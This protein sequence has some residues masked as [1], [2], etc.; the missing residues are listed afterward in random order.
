MK[1]TTLVLLACAWLQPAGMTPAMPTAIRVQD[2]DDDFR[3]EFQK[4]LDGAQKAEQQKLVKAKSHEA[5]VWIDRI[6][7]KLSVEPDPA[8]QKLFDALSE[9]WRANFAKSEFPARSQSYY[10]SLD[11]SKRRIRKD[12]TDR[13]K[14]AWREFDGNLQKK[15]GLVFANILDEV[16]ALAGAFESEGDLFHASEAYRVH[17]QMQDEVLRGMSADLHGAWKSY[18][19]AIGP[20]EKLDLKD[21]VLE[22][23][24]KRH[25]ALAARGADQRGGA[26]PAEPGAGGAAGGAKPAGPA[27]TLSAAMSF[28]MLPS[29]DAIQRPLYALDENH[30]MW[31]GV[32]LVKKDSMEPIARNSEC[33]P[34]VRTGSSDIRFDTD[35]D[36]K[37]DEKLTLTGNIVPIRVQIGKGASKRPWGFFATTGIQKDTY[38][39]V[40]VNLAPDDSQFVLYVIG[41]ASITG[42]LGT[43]PVRIIDDTMD[44]NYGSQPQ[45]WGTLGMTANHYEP[46]MDSIVIGAGKRARPYSELV[47]IEG[48]W[49]KLE[50]QENGTKLVA[51]PADVDTGVLKLDFK[52]PVAPSYLVMVGSGDTKHCYFDLV[53]GGAKGVRVPVGSYSLYYG[54]IR[55]GKK[56]QT[57]KAA[58]VPPNTGAPSWSVRRNEVTNV[59]LGAPFGF[60]FRFETEGSKI[61]VLGNTIA[62]VGSAGERYERPWN[63]VAKPEA[64]WRKKG[65]KQAGGDE[66]MGVG[67]LDTINNAD[68]GWS[69]VW[70][71]LN[72]E[73]DAKQA[74]TFEVQLV[75]KKHDLFGKVES[76]WKE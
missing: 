38:Q 34:L 5:A 49:Y 16:E 24:K 58:I 60:D 26:A 11:D 15:D 50:V 43:T 47:E 6:A 20:R 17:G 7:E 1:P 75:Q 52:G 68:L 51:L 32:R 44:G 19:Y 74:A 65:A 48:R 53:E 30:P 27:T 66:K 10:A 45:T 14:V 64:L 22:E 35:G 61:K 39:G 59:T 28:E 31:E 21:P 23:L 13:W 2:A 71:P 42:M 9:A 54:E 55:K 73:I 29:F 70:F 76:V 25:A 4:Q 33:P 37:G 36:G 57:Q 72:T 56:K 12:L 40:E 67:S 41:G 62:V 46:L 3:R 63:A 69:S 18:G 8:E